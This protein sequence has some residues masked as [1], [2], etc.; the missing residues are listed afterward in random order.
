MSHLPALPILLPMLAGVLLLLPPL[1]TTLDR[2]RLGSL[3]IAG[4]NV[5]V[6]IFLLV[7]SNEG[8]FNLYALGDWQP[9]FGIVL[10]LDRLSALLVFVTAVLLFA[11]LLYASVGEDRTG[12]YFYPLMMF[13]VM[14]ING[15]FLT[16]DLFNLFVFFEI[17]LIASYSLLIHGGGKHKTQASVHY[18]LLNLV[19]SSVFL[20]G[21]AILYGAVGSLNM[22][23]MALRIRELDG[24]NLRLAEVGGMLLMV[25][26]GLK[27][28]MLPLQ[29]W[30][31]RTYTVA[32]GPVAALFAI[33]T[34]IGVYSMIRVH[35]MLFGDDAGQLAGMILPWLWALGLLTLTIGAIGAISSPSL[36]RTTGH[37]VIVS[38][39][40]LLIAL[41]VNSEQ[42]ISA[43]VYY[44]VHSTFAAAAL[45]LIADLIAEQRGKTFDRIV[46]SRALAQPVA[47]GIAF[48]IA[49]LSLIGMPP[50]SGF[51]GKLMVLAS[52]ES[53]TEMGWGWSVL[54]LSSLAALV[55]FSRA[56]STLFWRTSGES[57]DRKPA[58]PAKFIAIWLL[59]AAAPLMSVFAGP[60]VDFSN[61]TAL[62]LFELSSNP[63]LLLPESGE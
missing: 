37:L 63:A 50:L 17:L 6:A 29:F 27:A 11:A 4:I 26:F 22:A 28:A 1:T 42:S 23:D 15:A 51:I 48:F 33:M 5:L 19:G 60:V 56:G 3:I 39:G 62:Q 25:V 30:L 52:M 61:A 31:P 45:F 44:A 53:T 38:V 43:A 46:R 47:I 54:L 7:Q 36:K 49:A 40:T 18:V 32:V 24:T 8:V 55:A 10:V 35:G 14:G 34:K 2:Q 12:P 59:L 16:G 57:A 13:Q 9:P 20:F 41:A 21:I 58:E